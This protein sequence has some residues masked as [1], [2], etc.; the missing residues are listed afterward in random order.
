MFT[1]TKHFQSQ[2]D[3]IEEGYFGVPGMR[4]GKGEMLKLKYNLKSKLEQQYQE[5]N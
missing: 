3:F 5:K 2:V 4:Y 1:S